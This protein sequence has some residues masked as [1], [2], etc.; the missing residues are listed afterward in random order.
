LKLP[1]WKK[2][3]IWRKFEGFSLA[4][5]MSNHRKSQ[6]FSNLK[7]RIKFKN[8]VTYYS[9]WIEKVHKQPPISKN[10]LRLANFPTVVAPKNLRC[11]HNPS[12]LAHNI[13]LSSTSYFWFWDYMEVYPKTEYSSYRPNFGKLPH[14]LCTEI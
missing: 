5:S 13:F 9:R 8:M 2:L 3:Q 11:I 7:L 6:T 10:I 1:F 4:I 14:N 12:M